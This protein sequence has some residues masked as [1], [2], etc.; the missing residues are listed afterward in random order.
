MLTPATLTVTLRDLV[1]DTGW[2][3]QGLWHLVLAFTGSITGIQNGDN[4]TAN[5]ASAG[6]PPFAPVGSY[7]ITVTLND[8]NGKLGNYNV[9]I[10]PPPLP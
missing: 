1:V 3:I 5:Y 10:D 2:Q 6:S 4:I 8:P 9:I 7:P